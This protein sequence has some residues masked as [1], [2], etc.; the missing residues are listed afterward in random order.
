MIHGA[1]DKGV[2][3]LKPQSVA[4]NAT[5]TGNIDTRGY[6][7]CQLDILLDSAAAVSSNPAVLKLAESDDTVV[8]NFADITAFV[9]DG[10]GGFTVPNAD[11]ETPQIVRMNVDL[12]KN[13]KRY[14]RL[15][16]TPAGAAQLL[17]A[18][19]RLGRGEEIATV[20]AGMGLAALVNG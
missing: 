14:L 5:A 2:I 16:A 8:T 9:G 1:N 20:A 7:F 10:T 11:T 18:T 3:A 15:S 13:R 12:R 4:T 19:A 6:D 17:A